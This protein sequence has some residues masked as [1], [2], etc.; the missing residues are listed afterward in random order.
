MQLLKEARDCRQPSGEPRRRWFFNDQVDFIAWYDASDAPGGFQLC[1]RA[2]RDE[3][4]LTWKPETGF[5]HAIVDDGEK[6]PGL[7][8]KGTPVL[9]AHE[10]VDTAQ[11]AALLRTIAAQLPP[12][13]AAFIAEKLP[14]LK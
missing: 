2:D 9:A 10:V 12:D 14:A 8:H 6:N 11:P 4:A 1:Y 3:L 7:S 13:I 5:E